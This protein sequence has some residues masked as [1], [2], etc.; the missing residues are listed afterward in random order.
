MNNNN[1]TQNRVANVTPTDK[2]PEHRKDELELVLGSPDAVIP[3]AIKANAKLIDGKDIKIGNTV[4]RNLGE[5]Y[6]R[7]WQ[8]KTGKR[9]GETSYTLFD[10]RYEPIV[11]KGKDNTKLYIRLSIVTF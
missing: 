7:A 2:T 10:N 4:L 9:A 11:I 5:C 6:A 3:D 8:S 1:T